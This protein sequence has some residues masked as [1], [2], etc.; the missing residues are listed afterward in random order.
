MT[1]VGAVE[2]A[3]GDDPDGSAVLLS[4]LD[5]RPQ[6]YRDWAAAYFERPSLNTAA[7]APVF[8]HRPLTEAVLD[9][10]HTDDAE[11]RSLADLADDI[12]EIGYPA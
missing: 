2:F 7:V 5:G 6:T 8:T 1:P 11:R 9:E 12:A 4:P 3:G 10:L